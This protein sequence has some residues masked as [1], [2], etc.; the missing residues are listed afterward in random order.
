M[1]QTD[2]SKKLFTNIIEETESH[3]EQH[4][5]GGL[6]YPVL[7]RI[8]ELLPEGAE[9]SAETG[10]GRSTILFSNLV[11]SHTVFCLEDR[12][13]GERSSVKYFED[14]ELFQNDSVTRVY[15][16][17]QVTLPS[18]EHKLQYDCVLIDSP[19]GY[20]F[21][22]IEYNYFY[23]HIKE[24]GLLI[25]DDVQI[26]SIGRMADVLQEDEMWEFVELVLTTAIF[27]RTSAPCFNPTGDG[28]W[29]QGFNRR[30]TTKDLHFYLEDGGELP[31]FE[32]RVEEYRQQRAAERLAK[33]QAYE[34][35]KR[36]K[37]S[38]FK[39]LFK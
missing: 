29:E 16:P 23:P 3:R 20:P 37:K 22:E 35:K 9:N 13:Y 5:A 10:C 17:T 36:K 26:A 6:Q 28:W 21:P 31:S 19:H 12:E 18:F 33:Q 34:A 32:T 2:N 27:R 7:A 1:L 38:F 25:I 14:S 4:I 24:G 15:G 8:E 39:R 11:K 30:R